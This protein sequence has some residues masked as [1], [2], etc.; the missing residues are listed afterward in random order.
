MTEAKTAEQSESH[1][2]NI[3]TSPKGS[4]VVDSKVNKIPTNGNCSLAFG[5][6][7]FKAPSQVFK[8]SDRERVSGHETGRGVRSNLSATYA[9]TVKEK[10]TSS[11]KPIIGSRTL[12]S[13]L[14]HGLRTVEQKL[15]LFVS[16]I[17][18]EVTEDKVKDYLNRNGVQDTTCEKLNTRYN[19]YCSYKVTLSKNHSESVLNA[20]FWPAGTL[21]REF[22]NRRK[23]V[24]DFVHSRTFLGM[25]QR[26]A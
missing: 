9:A 26:K 12:D 4:K 23:S 7:K 1:P 16:R 13:N 18:P 17:H 15:V 2:T 11:S 21:I 6:N 22:V 25:S 19:T 10:G 8:R 5:G 3:E 20:N 14:T 24:S